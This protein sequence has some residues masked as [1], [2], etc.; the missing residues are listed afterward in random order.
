MNS[1]IKLDEDVSELIE[2]D[3]LLKTLNERRLERLK[4]KE[5]S[6]ESLKNKEETIEEKEESFENSFKYE[7]N[8]EAPFRSII[9]GL[10]RKRR[11]YKKKTFYNYMYKEIGNS[12][13]GQV[14]MGL[15]G[16]KS[17]DI[18]TNTYV[19]REGGLLSNPI[20]ASYITGFTRALIG[21]CLHNI[22][23]LGGRV[24]SVTTDGF[25]ADVKDLENKL[26]AMNSDNLQCLYLYKDIR[27]LLTT[28][29]ED[30]PDDKALE[31]KNIET[32]GILS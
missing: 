22:H 31:I 21:E 18:K 27:K 30:A 3:D 26:L 25:I 17:F 1:V 16:K 8:Y 28:F 24:I 5:L 13:Y 19:R 7:L 23:L 6:T 11:G 32:K 15:S 4:I 10:Q 9:K 12:I 2:E 14:S 20:L 29:E